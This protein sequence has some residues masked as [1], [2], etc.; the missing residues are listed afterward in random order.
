MIIV[1]APS[2]PAHVVPGRQTASYGDDLVVFLIG[3]RV[4]RWRAVRHW[5]RIFRAMNPMLGE[6][7]SDPASGLL[8]FRVMFGWRQVSLVQY[9]RDSASLQSFAGDPARSHRPAWLDFF[10]SAFA[11]GSV[12]FWHET[13][14]VPAGA[15]ESIYGNMPRTGLGAVAGVVPVAQRGDSFGERLSRSRS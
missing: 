8:G 9:W 5:P 6:L 12:G 15:Y 4:N 13:Y 7:L 1:A 2:T 3:M 11:S 14:V 10:R